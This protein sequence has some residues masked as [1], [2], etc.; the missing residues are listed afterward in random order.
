MQPRRTPGMTVVAILNFICGILIIPHSMPYILIAFTRLSLGHFPSFPEIGMFLYGL[1]PLVAGIAALL[2]AIGVLRVM[3][4][5]RTLS[6]VY[7]GVSVLYSAVSLFIILTS[8]S[9]DAMDSNSDSRL[10]GLILLQG[11]VYPIILIVLFQSPQWK[12]KFEIIS[13]PPT[14]PEERKNLSSSIDV[15]DQLSQL[16]KL[17]EENFIDEEEYN[18]KKKELLDLL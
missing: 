2:G 16:K 17:F 3:P 10:I 11:L 5:G 15:Q 1:L 12:E 6:L 9:R 7:A 8:Q 13:D 4:R 18:R 14:E